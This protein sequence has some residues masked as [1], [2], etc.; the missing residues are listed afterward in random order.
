MFDLSLTDGLTHHYLAHDC[1]RNLVK[2]RKG[3]EKPPMVS[4]GKMNTFFRGTN[5]K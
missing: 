2:E 4:L 3:R 5:G 1:I